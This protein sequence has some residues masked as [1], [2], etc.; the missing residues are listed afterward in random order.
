MNNGFLA[1]DVIEKIGPL[2]QHG[3]TLLFALRVGI[4]TGQPGMA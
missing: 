3:D 4:S 1:H 2:L